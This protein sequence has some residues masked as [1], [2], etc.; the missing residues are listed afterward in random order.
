MNYF[1][2]LLLFI[3]LPLVF[4]LI[5]N[6]YQTREKYVISP[7]IAIVGLV[8]VAFI[9]TTPWDNYLVA[10][11]IWFYDPN[12][13]T[14]YTLGWVPIEEYLFFIVQTILLG[15][16]F[17]YVMK[18]QPLKN[19]NDLV[20]ERSVKIRLLSTFLLFLLWFPTVLILILNPDPSL[21]YLSLILAWGLIPVGLQFIYG[22]DIIL[23]YKKILVGIIAILGTYL[24]IIDAIA[25][26]QGI[27]TITLSTS[28]GILIGG[29]LPIEE[30][31][32]F[33]LTS[34]LVVFGMVLILDNKSVN[35]AKNLF[36]FNRYNTS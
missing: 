5:L 26:E 22:A 23:V 14:G 9:Y 4:F 17:L 28:T 27:W 11:N 35:R 16:I 19:Q 24:S 12:L 30:A 1:D 6:L 31:V 15:L 13:V 34:T 2:F 33:F 3:G 25:I 36:G 18:I 20:T 10:E 32:F 21:T 7:Y 8:I 29:I